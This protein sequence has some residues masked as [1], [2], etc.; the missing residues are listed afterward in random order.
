MWTFSSL[1]CWVTEASVSSSKT[2]PQPGVKVRGDGPFFV[3]K[4][5]VTCVS[6]RVRC[7]RSCV[8]SHMEPSSICVNKVF[9]KGQRSYVPVCWIMRTMCLGDNW[10][11]FFPACLG[12][13]QSFSNVLCWHVLWCRTCQVESLGWRGR[14]AK[15]VWFMVLQCEKR[16]GCAVIC[17]G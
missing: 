1:G 3:W 7:H 6:G 15:S 13:S 12:W 16:G 14:G 17:S 4:V 2:T 9:F 5:S 11:I 8:K 10:T